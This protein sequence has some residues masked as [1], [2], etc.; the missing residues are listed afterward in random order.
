M[1]RTEAILK[2]RKL[3]ELARRGVEGERD[4][5]TRMFA[6]FM[7]KN[8]LRDADLDDVPGPLPVDPVAVYRDYIK[9]AKDVE[10]MAADIGPN[11]FNTY[12]GRPPRPRSTY[13]D[14]YV[15]AAVRAYKATNAYVGHDPTRDEV[16]A[17]IIQAVATANDLEL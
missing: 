8:G 4:N 2:A 6:A 17:F 13:S 12:Q 15:R 5:A 16:V 10:R 1:E 11:S 9:E 3:R 7:A 14:M